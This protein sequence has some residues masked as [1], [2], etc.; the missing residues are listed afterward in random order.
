LR[1]EIAE[2]RA[3]LTRNIQSLSQTQ[4]HLVQVAVLRKRGEFSKAEQVGLDADFT[5]LSSSSWETAV[6]TQAVNYMDYSDV[7]Q[8]A[9]I[10]NIQR[11]LDDVQKEAIRFWIEGAPV[12]TRPVHDDLV[13]HFSRTDSV[14]ATSQEL[15]QPELLRG[16]DSERYL[17]TARIYLRSIAVIESKLL[18]A[19]DKAAKTGE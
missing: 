1:S 15:P 16:T 14:A 4:Q 18:D 6:A 3:K 9:N 8:Y 17:E 2:N 11:R 7:E 19:Y 12:V 5:N 10:Y 13:V